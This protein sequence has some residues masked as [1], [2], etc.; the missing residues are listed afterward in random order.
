MTSMIDVR[1]S[2][3]LADRYRLE[4]V[5]G[6]GG[7]AT[8]YLAHDLRHHRDVAVKVLHAAVAGPA[9]R[10]RFLDEIR[11]AAG[12]NHPHILPLFDSGDAGGFLF[13]VMPVMQGQTL[14]ERLGR[15]APLPVGDAVGIAIDVADALD[16]AHRHNVLHRDIKPENILLHEGHAAVADFGI[17]KVAFAAA[18]DSDAATLT[19]AGRLIGTPAYMSPEQALGEELDGR[20]DLFSL[21]C[22]LYEM[23]TGQV[24]F[25]GATTQAVIARRLT[26]SPAR[27]DTLRAEVP[28]EVADVVARLLKPAAADRYQ[29]GAEVTAALR[30][31]PGPGVGQTPITTRA[32]VVPLE[33]S[34]AVLPFVNMSADPENEFFSDGLTEELI[35][36]L[37]RVH[38]LRVIS[39]TS[40][41]QQKHSTRSLREIGRE[42]GVTYLLTGSVRKAGTNLR[43]TAQLVDACTDA[44]LWGEKYSG[45]ADDVFDVQERVSR[46][47]VD[48]LDVTLR[49]EESQRLRDRPISNV[50]AFELYLQAR[51]ELRQYNVDRAR[52]LIDRAISIEGEVP[53]LRALRAMSVITGMRAG[54]HRDAAQLA[55]AEAEARALI[56]LEPGNAQG[57]ALLGYAAYERGD[58]REAVRALRQ[59]LELEPADEDML[60]HLGISLE[61]AGRGAEAFELGQTM[62]ANDPL[63]PM[64]GLLAGSAS[65]FVGR[66][67]EGIGWMERSLEL[68]PE[69]LIHHWAVGYHYCLLGRAGEGERHAAWMHDRQPSVVYSRQLRA[70]VA[71]LQGRLDEARTILAAVDVSGLDGHQLFHVAESIIMSGDTVGGMAAL[72]LAID[73]SFCP[74]DFIAV[75][76]PFLEPLRREAG[77]TRL[78]SRAARRAD[79][80]SERG[81]GNAARSRTDEEAG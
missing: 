14:R 75:H 44:Q 65:W 73:R 52:P 21:G 10:R 3:A 24:A 47:I 41:M 49:P 5:L 1:L 39:R 63:S 22:V 68:A 33:K 46:A 60:F 16:Y 59:A 25:T 64:A 15:E 17:A 18:G 45:T 35:I 36:D 80:L 57:H 69:S 61:A 50:R 76:C 28:R 13:F 23:A 40:S 2:A 8:V 11:L 72:E 78:L 58:L 77:F 38:A 81:A 6:S 79:E 53:A 34:I 20:S 26:H 32:P 42:L 66:A 9:E 29:T 27:V 7:M 19:G 51:Q 70:L 55:A 37:S 31:A 48:A 67:A 43:I 12:L 56:A 71:A 62:I 30:A 54:L 74:Y 4:R